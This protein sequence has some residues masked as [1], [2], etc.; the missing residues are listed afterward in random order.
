MET[1]FEKSF[2]SLVAISAD[3]TAFLLSRSFIKSLHGTK[4]LQK[5]YQFT[6]SSQSCKGM[7][8]KSNYSDMIYWKLS[9]ALLS[10]KKSFQEERDIM[11]VGAIFRG[12]DYNVT[13]F[14]K[15]QLFG[16]QSSRTQFSR[17]EIL[18]GRTNDF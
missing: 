3:W 18:R 11:L 8:Y 2:N 9:R 13:Q 1:T 12:W 6:T 4:P 14:S 17:G 15:K 10:K 16:V 5:L 7:S